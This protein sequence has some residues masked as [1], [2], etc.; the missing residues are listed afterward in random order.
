MSER[1]PRDNS[2]DNPKQPELSPGMK[3]VARF[4]GRI[5]G[6]RYPRLVEDVRTAYAE[7]DSKRKL[8]EEPR[9]VLK[10]AMVGFKKIPR[11]GEVLER[12]SQDIKQKY[13][14]DAEQRG[15]QLKGLGAIYADELNTAIRERGQGGVVVETFRPN[16]DRP[17]G[18]GCGTTGCNHRY[19]RNGKTIITGFSNPNDVTFVAGNDNSAYRFSAKV[20]ELGQREGFVKQV[21]IPEWYIHALEKHPYADE[22]VRNFAGK[23]DDIVTKFGNPEFSIDTPHFP[24]TPDTI[25]DNFL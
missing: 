1:D 25:P 3:R 21:E 9:D 19:D 7:A 11:P 14:D 12:V 2:E 22:G 24:A 8:P 15:A 6:R 20:P 4:L 23:I 17:A 18:T 5:A 13:A 10:E 16:P